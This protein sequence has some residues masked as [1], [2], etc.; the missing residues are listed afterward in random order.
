[1]EVEFFLKVAKEIA[2]E[3]DALIIRCLQS[4]EI[5]SFFDT[6][7]QSI[8]ELLTLYTSPDFSLDLGS[9]TIKE[10]EEVAGHIHALKDKLKYI[11]DIRKPRFAE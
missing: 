9:L 8:L 10:I 2:A 11:V 7:H 5:D 1:M 3:A 4:H 6:E